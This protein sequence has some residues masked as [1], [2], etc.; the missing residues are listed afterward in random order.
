M[1]MFVPRYVIDCP[2]AGA[3]TLL[4]QRATSHRTVSAITTIHS[5]SLMRRMTALPRASMKRSSR[6]VC[7]TRHASGSRRE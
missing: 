2:V 6:R 4:C 7:G 5:T 1:A 3:L